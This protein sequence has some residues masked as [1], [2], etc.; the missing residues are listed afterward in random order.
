MRRLIAKKKMTKAGLAALEGK[1]D[2]SAKRGRE[3]RAA[4]IPP[5][6]ERALKKD[7]VVWRNFRT[8][9]ASY[10]RI[11]VGWIHFSRRRPSEFRK[12]L[13]YFVR[14]TRANKRFGMVQ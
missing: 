2:V 11:R 4:K 3:T 14:M 13:A 7:P 5:D 6:I 8:F 10:R 9:P 12:R 1:L